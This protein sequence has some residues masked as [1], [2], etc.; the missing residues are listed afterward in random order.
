MISFSLTTSRVTTCSFVVLRA[1][2]SYAFARIRRRL[3]GRPDR[4]GGHQERDQGEQHAERPD[5]ARPFVDEWHAVNRLL[6]AAAGVLPL[7]AKNTRRR[8]IGARSREIAG[9]Q[10]SHRKPIV[11]RPTA[12]IVPVA[13]S[14]ARRSA[15]PPSTATIAHLTTVLV[16]AAT[17]IALTATWAS[18]L[19]AYSAIDKVI[20]STSVMPASAATM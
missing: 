9:T 13:T 5:T 11:P 16:R 1:P 6:R 19:R 2:D 18:P 10:P 7:R 15:A 12:R 17:T 14:R 8:S 20:A 4:M 3:A